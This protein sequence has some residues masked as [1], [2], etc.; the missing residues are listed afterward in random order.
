MDFACLVFSVTS[1]ISYMTQQNN[2][3]TLVGKVVD[4]PKGW[5]ELSR[6]STLLTTKVTR[7]TTRTTT[8]PIS[9]TKPWPVPF[10]ARRAPTYIAKRINGIESA[11]IKS[12]K[13]MNR[14][15]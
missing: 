11:S 13:T 14:L 12:G 2:N 7:S 6:S 10:K 4:Y 8:V 5:L 3:E 15:T 9:V 1:Q